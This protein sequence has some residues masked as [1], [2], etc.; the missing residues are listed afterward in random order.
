MKEKRTRLEKENMLVTSVFSYFHHIF[1]SLLCSVSILGG[2]GCF[3]A[4]PPFPIFKN[5][6]GIFYIDKEGQMPNIC[7]FHQFIAKSPQPFES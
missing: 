5:D 7:E 4:P 3:L 1:Q 2:G 6:G